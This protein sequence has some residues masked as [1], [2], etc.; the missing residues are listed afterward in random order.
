MDHVLDEAL[1][2]RSIR[3]PRRFRLLHTPER[4][5]R[6]LQRGAD[7]G[8]INSGTGLLAAVVRP[9]WDGTHVLRRVRGDIDAARMSGDADPLLSGLFAGHG[10][11]EERPRLRGGEVGLRHPRPRTDPVP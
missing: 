1:K 11:R 3:P 10:R 9:S 7:V 5:Q 8:L 2:R 4:Q 6:L